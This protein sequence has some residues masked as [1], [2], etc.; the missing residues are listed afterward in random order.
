[1]NDVYDRKGKV[2]KGKVRPE[3]LIRKGNTKGKLA[4]RSIP[5]ISDLRGLLSAY[6]YPE[7][8][9]LCFLGELVTLTCQRVEL[10]QGSWQ[11][12]RSRLLGSE[13]RTIPL[14]QLQSAKVDANES[15]KGDTYRVVLLTDGDKVPFTSAWSSGAE[16][17]QKKSDQINAFIG[18]SGKTSLRVQQDNCW[19]AYPFG[20]IFIL[21]GSGVVLGSLRLLKN[22]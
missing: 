19:V 5:V 12:V 7:R 13:E 8:G 15:S 11:F 18:N 6:Q 14:N 4:T 20:G 10:T 22:G 17:K 9:Y 3:L 21:L 2:R 16:E 1:M